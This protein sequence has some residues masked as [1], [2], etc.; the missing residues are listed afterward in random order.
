MGGGRRGP[1]NHRGG[2][3]QVSRAGLVVNGKSEGWLRKGFP[4]VY[5]E[6]ITSGRVQDGREVT[7]RGKGGEVLGRALLD[8]GWIAARVFRVEDKPIDEAWMHVRLDEAL[9]MRELRMDEGTNAYRVVNGVNDGLP[10]IRVDRWAHVFSIVL[11]TPSLSK[12]LPILVSWLK[13]RFKPRAVFLHYR[14]DKRETRSFAEADPAPG[15][16][17]GHPLTGPVRVSERGVFFDVLPALSHDAGLYSDVA[18]LRSWLEPSWG[19]ARVLNAFA[20]TG[21][22]SVFAALG[23]A[24]EVVTLDLAAPAIERARQ[25]FVIN[26][27]DPEAHTFV[28][29][30]A[31]KAFDRYRRTGQAFDRIILDPPAFS[32]SDGGT[33]SAAKDWPRLVTAALRC[34]APD[35]WLITVCNQGEISPHA[36]RG[37]LAKGASK[38]K[39]RMQVL[40]WSAHSPD[41]PALLGFPEGQYLKCAVL[42][43]MP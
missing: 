27:I 8:E 20:F 28:E 5:P 9:A 42:R 13:E 2:R 4:W 40:H 10:G 22:F 31:F 43:R 14:R 25:N 33:W 39:A 12:L 6:E 34:L 24:S 16:I 41:V 38:A 36:F 17:E 35:G 7:V 18:D 21:A 23:G 37:A 32:H 30:D 3:E 1:R 19:G 29:S 26:G 11:D 15:R